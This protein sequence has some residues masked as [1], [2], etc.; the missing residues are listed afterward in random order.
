VRLTHEASILLSKFLIP[1]TKMHALGND[2]VVVSSVDLRATQC[3][4]RLLKGWQ[5][6]APQLARALCDRNRGVGGDGL[7]LVIEHELTGK[8]ERSIEGLPPY[9]GSETADIGWIYTNSDGS[10]SDM[11]GNGLRCVALFAVERRLV[12]DHN[13]TLATAA[14]VMSVDY[15]SAH[16]ITVDMG[17]P[18]LVPERIPVVAR[19]SE[20]FVGEPIV[21]TENGSDR[22]LSA[23]CVN[24]GNPHCVIFGEEYDGA[25]YRDARLDSLARQIQSNRIFPQGV[26]VEFVGD[27]APAYARVLVWERGC[28]PTLACASGAAAVLVA[29]VLAGKLER[30]ATI[31]LPGGQLKAQWS[32]EDDHVRLTGSATEVF[33]GQIDLLHFSSLHGLLAAEATCT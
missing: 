4:S 5:N 20:R 3:G 2:F 33:N 32:G 8:L 12:S 21:I 24:M 23:T 17:K 25:A 6:F 26:N 27:I 10:S 30:T 31:E 11:C 18:E 28:G 14:G 1:F 9:K 16:A 13:F 7:I 29:G 19:N 22:P 15:Q